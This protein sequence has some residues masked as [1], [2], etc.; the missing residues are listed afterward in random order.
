[1][2][3]S[4]DGRTWTCSTFGHKVHK[5]LLNL[6]QM[7]EMQQIIRAFGHDPR[8][9]RCL[10][11]QTL[12][13]IMLSQVQAAYAEINTYMDTRLHPKNKG[14]LFEGVSYHSLNQSDG[15]NKG[16]ERFMKLFFFEWAIRSLDG[17]IENIDVAVKH[18]EKVIQALNLVT[19]EVRRHTDHD[20]SQ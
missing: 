13:G 18:G 14:L 5:E 1:M 12:V 16:S 4:E 3:G 9:A 2:T 20:S 10:I 15:G 11:A 7:E 6:G 8:S 19:N 17:F